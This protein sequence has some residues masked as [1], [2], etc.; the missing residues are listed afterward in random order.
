MCLILALQEQNWTL[1][2]KFVQLEGTLNPATRTIDLLQV[3]TV[4]IAEEMSNPTPVGPPA[5]V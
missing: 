3:S 4:P 5:N 1:L 2:T